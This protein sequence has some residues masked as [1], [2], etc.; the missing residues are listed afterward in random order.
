MAE[1]PRDPVPAL[2]LPRK[3]DNP[4]PKRFVADIEGDTV[5]L[6]RPGEGIDG[7]DAMFGGEGATTAPEP[8]CML[9]DDERKS[10]GISW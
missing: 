4:R 7:D 5:P 9:P 1:E 2:G 6:L 8:D 10:I 3:Y